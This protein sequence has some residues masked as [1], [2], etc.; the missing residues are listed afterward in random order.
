LF[1]SRLIFKIKEGYCVSLNI[2]RKIILDTETTG[3]D[4][5]KGDRIVEI[6][7]VEIYNFVPTGK[8]FHT[9]INPLCEVSP[10]ATAITGLTYDFLKDFPLFE[11]IVAGFLDFIGTSSL[12]IHNAPFDMKFINAEL[13]R[14]DL[15]EL[16][17]TRTIDTLPLARRL[18]PG[19]PASLDALC[20]RFGVDNS[21]RALHGALLD[22]TLLADVYL[23]LIGGRQAGLALEG[24]SE[25]KIVSAAP[26]KQY[27][28]RVF[29]PSS[30]ELRAHET[31]CQQLKEPLWSQYK[32]EAFPFT[33]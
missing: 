3:L 14:L 19:A 20:R 16:E 12:V 2:H 10:D 26:L 4:P 18:F 21:K 27:P 13:K 6:G 25:Q 30:K 5:T 7:C 29:A 24:P 22:C 32:R 11:Q 9:Y 15:P 31:F 23:H 28:V 17:M 33:C 8:T 1:Y